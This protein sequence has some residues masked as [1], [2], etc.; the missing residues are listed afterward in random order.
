MK[1]QNFYEKPEIEE[2][3]LVLE[4]SFLT[5]STGT[6]PGGNQGEGEDKPGGE[7]PPWDGDL[8]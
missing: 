5:G 8:D 7:E 3:N 1:K 6:T 2:V 4:G